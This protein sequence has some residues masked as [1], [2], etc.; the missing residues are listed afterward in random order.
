VILIWNFLSAK[1]CLLSFFHY[2][3]FFWF[4]LHSCLKKFDFH[5]L[6]CLDRFLCFTIKNRDKSQN[7]ILIW[8]FLWINLR[9]W[10]VFLQSGVFRFELPNYLV[11]CHLYRLFSFDR[12]LSLFNIVLGVISFISFSMD[13]G[14]HEYLSIYSG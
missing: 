10:S 2:A 6:F 4:E 8:N 5:Q 7:S 3:N 14:N 9:L 11:E 1:Y 12:F 13:G